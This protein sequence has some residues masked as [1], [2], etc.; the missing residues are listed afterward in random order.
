MATSQLTQHL[1]ELLLDARETLEVE[2][3][4]WIDIVNSADHKAVLAKAIIALANH[5]GGVIIIGFEKAGNAMM[6]AQSRPANLAGYTPDTVNAVVNRYAEPAFHCDVR[7]LSAPGSSDTY[8]IIVVPGGHRLPIRAKRDGPNRQTIQQNTYYIRR[9]GPQ[10]EPPQTAQEWDAL[11]RRCLSNAREKLLN[12]F[13]FL[14]DGAPARF[15]ETELDRV[16][17]WFDASK[18]RWKERTEELPA[19]HEARLARGCYRVGFELASDIEPRHGAA[20]VEALRAG[21]VRHSG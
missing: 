3:K 18:A 9:P 19:A 6:S 1:P 21:V 17:Q 15:E 10:S 2:L 20:L 16:R 13:R 8:P 5:G 11:M 12:S 7:I 14:M 4:G